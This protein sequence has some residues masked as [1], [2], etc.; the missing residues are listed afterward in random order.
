MSGVVQCSMLGKFGR[1]GNSLFQYVFARAYAEKYEARLEIPEDWVGR[2]VFK[3]IDH[4]GLSVNFPRTALDCVD[5]GEVNI[6]LFGYFQKHQFVRLLEDAKV[7]EWLTLKDEWTEKFPKKQFSVVAHLR[8]GDYL[9]HYSNIFCVVSQNSYKRKVLELGLSLEDLTWLE[10][11]AGGEGELSFMPDFMFMVNADVLLRAN[12]TFSFWAGYLNK[13][14][15]FS[16]VVSGRQ[17]PQ[18]VEFVEG[19]EESIVDGNPEFRFVG[20]SNG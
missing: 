4:D 18:D 9:T 6:D 3:D 16:P 10:E 15:V 8:R 2:K 14:K 13:G 11:G 12:S 20:E 1:F 5:F 7:R 19:N 17:G